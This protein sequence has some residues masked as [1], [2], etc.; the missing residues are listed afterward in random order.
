MKY[1]IVF[2]CFWAS[3]ASAENPSPDSSKADI[4]T[5]TE[6]AYITEDMAD[7]EVTP[8]SFLEGVKAYKNQNFEKALSIFYPL[9]EQYPNNPTLLYNTGLVQYQMGQ[10]GMALGL[11]RKARGLQANFAPINEAII[12]VE[13]QLFPDQ[14]QDS[15]PTVLYKSLTSLPL[16]FWAFLCLLFFSFG[17]YW[18]LEYGVKKSLPLNLWPN[19]IFACLPV[20]LFTGFFAFSLYFQQLQI[21]AT[22][23]TKNQLTHT[24]PSKTSPTLSELDE[25]QI[26]KI[27]KEHAGWIQIRTLSGSPGWV[28]AQSLIIFKGI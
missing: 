25:G 23:I 8:S 27:E 26:V 17:C 5:D 18:A 6:T 1:F 2:L 14:Q 7:E 28:P 24:N 22:I 13:E 4:K 12:F 19:W 21:M 15:L 3:I 10:S 16:S 9:I 20:V 11:W